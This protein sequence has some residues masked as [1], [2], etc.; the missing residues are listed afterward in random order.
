MLTPEEKCELLG[1]AREAIGSIL[2]NK[3]FTREVTTSDALLKPQGA[4]VTLRVGGQLRGCIGYIE[5]ANSLAEV[6]AEVAQKAACE[7]PRFAPLSLAEYQDCRIE[8][9]VLSP[10]KQITSPDEIQVG[11]HG[12]LLE[13]GLHRGLLLP[14][15][16]V[17]FGWDQVAFLN[18]VARKAGL[19]RF[20]PAD[21]D[22]KVFVFGAEVLKE[23]E[24][25]NN[26]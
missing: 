10:L 15:V 25:I 22:A 17:E 16:A 9:S 26:A 21:P 6:V 5:S 20:D 12:V 4:F 1:I 19:P 13:V 2:H 14:Q 23:K 24:S 8:I 18:A 11:I 7:D 3:P